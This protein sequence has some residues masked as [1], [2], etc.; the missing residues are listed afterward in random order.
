MISLIFATCL[1]AA[2]A[3]GQPWLN[4]GNVM[5]MQPH[6][7]SYNA[8]TYA[9][10]PCESNEDPNGRWVFVRDQQHYVHLAECQQYNGQNNCAYRSAQ[11]YVHPQTQPMMYI[12]PTNDCETQNCEYM[13]IQDECS[14]S[15][16]IRSNDYNG[17]R[18]S[19]N[20]PVP[21]VE[22]AETTTTSTTT[23]TP[24]PT[25]TPKTTP[26]S[27]PIL[28]PRPVEPK[29]PRRSQPINTIRKP[30]KSINITT[31]TTTSKP[32][33]VPIT[34]VASTQRPMNF[35]VPT[36]KT[37]KNNAKLIKCKNAHGCAPAVPQQQIYYQPSSSSSAAA[38]AAS[39]GGSSASASAS[40]AG[41]S[42]S[43]SA[44]ASASSSYM[45]FP[46]VPLQYNQ[47]YQNQVLPC[48]SSG[49]ASPCEVHY[50]RSASVN[51]NGFTI[52]VDGK[53]YNGTQ[54]SK[55]Q[56]SPCMQ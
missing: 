28:R 36:L 49:G 8:P 48:K 25:T 46:G 22:P 9:L 1:L 50:K 41:G 6:Y 13:C 15:F 2:S 40:A 7:N 26:T 39:S 55:C 29:E 17:I 54:L 23:T 45:G 18:E 35:D 5:Q 10:Y 56:N 16:V 34:K 27:K 53:K 20:A 30:I 12:Q 42:S 3:L 47:Q 11:N 24:A 14:R 44:S 19:F 21:N 51:Q 43:A 31:T 32:S 33:V 37:Q 52:E 4:H 38:A